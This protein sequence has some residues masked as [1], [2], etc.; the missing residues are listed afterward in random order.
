MATA[1][2]VVAPGSVPGDAVEE[3]E[4]FV[5]ARGKARKISQPRRWGVGGG[6]D[7]GDYDDEDEDEDESEDEDV[8]VDEAA[9]TAAAAV[10]ANGTASSPR[11]AF[12]AAAVA[13][14]DDDADAN[15]D[16]DDNGAAALRVEGDADDVRADD[17]LPH[18]TG[19]ERADALAEEVQQ[20]DDDVMIME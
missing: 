10:E 12:T 8:R 9:A 15:V 16:V 20:E 1:V 11:A 5:V 2:G 14:A 7:G 19:S 4:K 17:A 6:L 18:T 3:A 13:A